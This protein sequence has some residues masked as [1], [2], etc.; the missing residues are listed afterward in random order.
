M[1]RTFKSRLK[2]TILFE[3]VALF[4]ILPLGSVIFHIDP[5]DFGHV[6]VFAT[7]FAMIW[8]YFYNVCFDHFMMLA[9]SNLEK[10]ILI[11]IGHSILFE[12]G[13]LVVLAPMIAWYLGISLLAAVFM[14]VA[15]SVFYIVY[16]F[17][18]NWCYDT[19]STTKKGQN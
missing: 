12:L 17:F 8:N 6:A 9:F 19:L 13:L 3:V 7:A 1:M 4:L 5:W 2:H 14:D 10:T 11:R 16:A 15:F 18:F